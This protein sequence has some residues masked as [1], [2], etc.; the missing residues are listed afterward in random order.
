MSALSAYTTACQKRASEAIT[1]GFK[2][3]CDCWELN[4]GPPKEGYYAKPS[5]QH[6]ALVFKTGSHDIAHDASLTCNT[7]LD[8]FLDVGTIKM[9][10][11]S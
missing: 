11:F 4:S 1:S 5:L 6:N 9:Y 10:L 2:P 7:L 3:P 8:Y